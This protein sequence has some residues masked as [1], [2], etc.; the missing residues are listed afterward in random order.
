[1]E[2]VMWKRIFF[3]AACL[4]ASLGMWGENNA[5]LLRVN[6][7][8]ITAEEFSRYLK[9]YAA[10]HRAVEPQEYL[11]DFMLFKLKVADAMEHRWDTLPDFRRQY[12]ALQEEWLEQRRVSRSTGNLSHRV[13][14]S[15]LTIPL[16]QRTAHREEE[17]AVSR[18][19]SV[20]TLLRQGC[21]WKEVASRFHLDYQEEVWEPCVSLLK[22]F[23]EQLS[24]LSEGDFSRPF[25]SPV[26]LHVVKLLNNASVGQ[27]KGKSGMADENEK[28]NVEEV[29]DPFYLKEIHDGLLAAYW[30]KKIK[31]LP[32]KVSDKDLEQYFHANREKYKWEFPHFKGAV[33]HCA[34]KKIASKIKRRLKKLPM[35][36]WKK[37]LESLAQ[38]DSIY[39]TEMEAGLFQ[40]GT[41]AYVDKLSFKCGEYPV[42]SRYPYS[43]V[44]GKRLKKGPEEYQDVYDKVVKDF[45]REKEAV[46][47]Q[48]LMQHFRV[49][50]QQDVLKTVNCNRNNEE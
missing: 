49:E 35:E 19:D 13:C 4:I 26:G 3:T 9:K 22:E 24:S 25:F 29:G 50:I 15:C 48:G 1:M 18:M 16:S 5:V 46:F 23:K 6:G 28:R 38:G 17:Q 20:Y 47:L 33:I 12:A 37:E 32:D 34:N 45:R 21:T 31:V 10:Y 36:H 30:D 2:S 40:I 27:Q 43:F 39:R 42:H 44:I 14:L 11:T 8:N 41:N 7:E